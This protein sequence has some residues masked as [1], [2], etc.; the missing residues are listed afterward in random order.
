MGTPE[1]AVP[2][3]DIL[4]KHGFDIMA[5]IT[6]PD[7]PAGR[8]RKISQSAVKKYALENSIPV[9][10]PANLKDPAFTKKIATVKCKPTNRCSIQDAT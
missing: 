4:V 8:G 5:V 6:A 10:Q 1:F 3:L 9:L 2:S 7:K